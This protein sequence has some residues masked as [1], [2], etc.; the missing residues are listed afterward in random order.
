MKK[1]IFLFDNLKFL[2]IMT[3]V[4]GHC[5]YYM[6][7]NSNIMKS[8]F[9]FIYSF[10]MP[11]FIYL[12]GLFHSD[13]NV[14]ERCLLFIFLGYIMKAVLYLIKAV[15]F[16]KADFSLLSDAGVPWYM[17]ALAMFVACSYFLRNID[18]R[19]I[20]ILSVILAC[21][22]GYDK[23]VVDYLYLSRFVVFYPFY[24]LGQMTDPEL[25]LRLH[26]NRSLK[27]LSFA[28]IA[29]WAVLCVWKL[30]ILYFLRP[31]FTGRH[32]F[33]GSSALEA[34]GPLC[35]L[36]CILAA[37]AIGL[38]LI[39]LVPDR[40]LPFITDAGRHTLQ[41]YFWHRAIIYFMEYLKLDKILSGFAAGKILWLLFGVILTVIL[42][43]KFFEFPVANIQRSFLP[44]K[45]RKEIPSQ[46]RSC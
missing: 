23:S 28:G 1:R 36:F 34:Y 29:V 2:L 45:S 6:T 16:H 24:L 18:T 44:A 35:R 22:V 9:I 31:L 39:C 27:I 41:V 46:K 30:D 32:S 17:F 20:F 5:V 11:L 4:V 7:G 38:F 15:L 33:A 25:L 21:I 3:V 19:K 37:I 10:H 43:T 13:H 26:K 14:K 12:S 8:I 40:E 42:S